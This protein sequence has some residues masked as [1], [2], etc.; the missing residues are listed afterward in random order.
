MFATAMPLERW[1][2]EVNLRMMIGS[3]DFLG[4]RD[5][6]NAEADWLVIVDYWLES[7]GNVVYIADREGRLT[8]GSLPLARDI[9]VLECS[10]KE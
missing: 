3:P 8:T 6:C 2:E 9:K 5:L 7:R 1:I 4:R 10:T